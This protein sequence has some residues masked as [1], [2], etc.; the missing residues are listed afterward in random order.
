MFNIFKRKKWKIITSTFAM[1]EIS[2]WKKRDLFV[3]NKLELKWDMDNIL[4]HKNNTDLSSLEFQKVSQWLKDQIEK[5]LKIDFVELEQEA[6]LKV[7]EISANTNLLAKD[8]LHFGTAFA[9]AL[10]YECDTLIVTDGNFLK[11]ATEYLNKKKN[12]RLKVLTPGSFVK[13]YQQT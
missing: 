7:R 6:W 9:S 3:R 10:N 12:T 11:E 1:V 2:D 8:A 5:L 13:K 4:S